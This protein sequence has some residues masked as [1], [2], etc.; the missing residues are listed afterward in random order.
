LGY[1]LAEISYLLSQLLLLAIVGI[2]KLLNLSILLLD[3]SVVLLTS[4]VQR[5]LCL[6]QSL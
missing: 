4:T 2:V 5:F 1:S 3:K 6:L